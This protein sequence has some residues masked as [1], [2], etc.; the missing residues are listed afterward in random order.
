[1]FFLQNEE[2][3]YETLKLAADKKMF[4]SPTDQRSFEE[5]ELKKSI[6]DMSQDNWKV[7]TQTQPYRLSLLSHK[8]MMTSLTVADPLMHRGQF[9][10]C[11]L[12]TLVR[13]CI[14]CTSSPMTMYSEMV[15]KCA[16][17]LRLALVLNMPLLSCPCDWTLDSLPQRQIDCGSQPVLEVTWML[18]HFR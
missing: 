3:D 12:D 8:C 15:I 14:V 6:K 18:P 7:R 11:R 9:D 5:E 10:D 2:T 17:I 4:D 1:M 13:E 16:S